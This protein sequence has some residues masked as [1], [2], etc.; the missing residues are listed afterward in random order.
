MRISD[1]SSDVW[2]SDLIV[3]RQ[4]SAVV[5]LHVLA[6]LEG[7]FLTAVRRL[8]NI[9]LADIALEIRRISRIVRIGPDQQAVEGRDRMDQREGGF[10]VTVE[11]RRF[12]RHDEFQ[13]PSHFWRFRAR[14]TR[15]T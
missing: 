3:G 7:V 14:G 5:E 15:S 11:A 6:V 9:A 13:N 4:G 12:I 2:S 1:W 8:R 10:P